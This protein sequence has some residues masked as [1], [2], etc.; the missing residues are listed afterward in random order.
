MNKLTLRSK[1]PYAEIGASFNN[2][3]FDL[4]LCVWGGVVFVAFVMSFVVFKY[5]EQMIIDFHQL[6]HYYNI[7]Y[8]LLLINLY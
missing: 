7:T 2:S 8:Y 1:A 5:C 4:L 6:S 3:R